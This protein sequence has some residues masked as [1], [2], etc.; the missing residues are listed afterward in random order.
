MAIEMP[1]SGPTSPFNELSHPISET[2][3]EIDKVIRP[4]HEAATAIWEQ[5]NASL[6]VN[7]QGEITNDVN[8]FPGYHTVATG[9]EVVV[10][11][12]DLV[13]RPL[14]IRQE[15]V[16]SVGRDGR[17][18]V[19][20]LSYRKNREDE[21]DYTHYRVSRTCS[22]TPGLEWQVGEEHGLITGGIGEQQFVPNGNERILASGNSIDAAT[23][24]RERLQQI[25]GISK[26][27]AYPAPKPQRS[28]R[29]WLGLGSLAAKLRGNR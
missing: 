2:S 25:L 9:T 22:L 24:A 7:A 3:Q 15:T 26:E 23:A 10:T 21:D 12:S 11:P 17:A 5:A 20:D 16:I 8:V 4:A 27:A 13:D 19:T 1:H 29:T 28:P 14:H 18:I 6:G